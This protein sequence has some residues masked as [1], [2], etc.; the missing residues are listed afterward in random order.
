[1]SE[2]ETPVPAIDLSIYVMPAFVTLT[3]SD[4]AVSRRWYV[5]GLGLAVLAE[6]PGP[7]GSVT[8]LHLRRW[9]YQD[10]LLVPGRS[11]DAPPAR[12][13]RLTFSA[14]GANLDALV[15]QARAVGGGV[16]E[17]PAATPWNTRDVLARDP[18]GYEVV[19]TDSLPTELQDPE[20]AGRMERVKQQVL[21]QR[22][23]TP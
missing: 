5:E 3:V 6:V 23:T 9:R 22:D 2:V 13:V 12:G 20:F 8:L 17:G 7:S 4:L 15:A 16:V 21:L 19:F 11:P 18:D 14:H 1:M 10:L